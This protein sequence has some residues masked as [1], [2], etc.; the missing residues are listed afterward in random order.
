MSERM[1]FSDLHRLMLESKTVEKHLFDQDIALQ[2]LDDIRNGT[3]GVDYMTQSVLPGV[4]NR[5][6]GDIQPRDLHAS[7]SIEPHQ[8]LQSMHGIDIEN[9]LI[10]ALSHE[11][12]CEIDREIMD[13]L[14]KLDDEIDIHSISLPPEVELAPYKSRTVFEAGFFW[15]PYVPI[16]TWDKSITPENLAYEAG[17][18]V[19]SRYG[20]INLDCTV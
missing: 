7:W 19:V 12:T 3:P 8:H 6:A 14:R 16:M 20:V 11:L 9:E 5:G 18:E 4:S 15:C 10:A 17:K 13:D 2:Y 1:V